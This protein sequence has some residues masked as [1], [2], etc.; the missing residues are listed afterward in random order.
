MH[1][2]FLSHDEF[3]SMFLIIYSI[4]IVDLRKIPIYVHGCANVFFFFFFMAL[5]SAFQDANQQIPD[6]NPLGSGGGNTTSIPLHPNLSASVV[7]GSSSD[8]SKALFSTLDYGS[9]N[10]YETSDL[11]TP[12]QRGDSSEIGMEDLSFDQELAA[13]IGR[14][15]KYGVS[16]DDNGI[17]TGDSLLDDIPRNTMHS[18]KVNKYLGKDSI[19]GNASEDVFLSG[20]R[21]ESLSEQERDKLTGHARKHS[22]ES[23]GSDMSSIRGSELSNT[24]VT[25]SLGDNSVDLTGGAEA[26]STMEAFAST[27]IQFLNDVHVV[28]PLDQRNKMSRVLTTMQRRLVTAKT[29]M[30]DLIARLNQEVAVKDY[31]MT[32]V[33]S[34][35]TF[36]ISFIYLESCF[37]T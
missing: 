13:P 20:E 7:A 3:C 6:A 16:D 11:G 1:V 37:F 14:L 19:Y 36:S 8:V 33:R 18:E 4:S 34:L 29:D 21:M 26:P 35:F 28:L 24:G 10:A 27:E 32:K 5:F 23:V 12:R 2:W 15:V 31:L 9:D 22:A 25:N 17:L 30:E